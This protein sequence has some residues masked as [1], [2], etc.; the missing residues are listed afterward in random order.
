M[1][2]RINGSEVVENESQVNSTRIEIGL[3]SEVGKKMKR[4]SSP[5][6]R[7]QRLVNT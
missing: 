7:N 2:I 5:P 1:K 4:K 3:N 6:L